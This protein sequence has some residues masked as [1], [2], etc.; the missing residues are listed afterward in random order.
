MPN[1]IVNHAGDPPG[2]PYSL[3]GE[4]LNMKVIIDRIEGSIAVL[5]ASDNDEISFNLPL[6]YLPSGVKAGDH[7]DLTFTVDPESRK[8]AEERVKKLL[9]DLTKNSET[10]K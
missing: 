3:C 2:R 9:G 8:A 1:L 5:A 7:L 4:I 10:S 6:A